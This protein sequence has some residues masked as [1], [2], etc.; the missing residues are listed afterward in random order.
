MQVKDQQLEKVVSNAKKMKKNEGAWIQSD[1]RMCEF[2]V[3]ITKKSGSL[4]EEGTREPLG[5]EQDGMQSHRPNSDDAQELVDSSCAHTAGAQCDADGGGASPPS[6]V[7]SRHEEQGVSVRKVFACVAGMDGKV[8]CMNTRLLTN[9]ELLWQRPHDEGYVSV[10]AM[11]T[12]RHIE[13]QQAL[14][15][16][17]GAA[18]QRGVD[19]SWLRRRSRFEL[20][21]YARLWSGKQEISPYQQYLTNIRKRL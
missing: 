20:A 6:E 8:C 11:H 19:A 5:S 13:L 16:V 9:P 17:E 15:N 4:A 21:D 14:L 10:L 1:T 7:V 3:Q 12:K 18:K 2:T